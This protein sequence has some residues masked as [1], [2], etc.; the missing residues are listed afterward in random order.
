[1]KVSTLLGSALLAA[2]SVQ[3]VVVP[4]DDA[5][6]EP[7]PTELTDIL[8]KSK[9]QV[10]DEVSSNEEKLRKRG[11]TPGCTLGKLVFRRE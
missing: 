8:E 7:A 6:G 5:V 10:I 3:A 9:A 11:Q 1:M 2:A 4:R